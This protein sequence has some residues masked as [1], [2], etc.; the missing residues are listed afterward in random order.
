MINTKEI[1]D[2]LTEKLSDDAFLSNKGLSNEVGI[3]IACYE[4]KDE[5]IVESYIDKMKTMDSIK[6]NVISCDLYEI[7]LEICDAKK[8]TA[9]LPAMEERKPGKAFKELV[10]KFATPDAFI[11]KMQYEPHK[12]NDV[13]LITGVGKVYPY[14]RCNNI[15]ENIQPAFP[16]IPVVVLYPGDY[17]GQELKLFNKFSRNYYRAFNII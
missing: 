12:Q 6:A 4:P 17:T 13:L 10:A 9:K 11:D 7:F 2:K 1:L 3:H 14:M 8:V 5:M 15:L 16:D